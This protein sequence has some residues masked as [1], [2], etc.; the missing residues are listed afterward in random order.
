[1]DGLSDFELS[2]YNITQAILIHRIWQCL[3]LAVPKFSSHEA[4]ISVTNSAVTKL[5]FQS[6]IQQLLNSAI[7]QI[8]R[9]AVNNTTYHH[10]T[11]Q[12]QDSEVAFCS[13]NTVTCRKNAQS[14]LIPQIWEEK[15]QS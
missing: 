2:R 1:M 14:I 12:M 13:V 6:Q 15:E 8:H 10:T 7:L 4:E 3:N 5:N 9:S 11:I